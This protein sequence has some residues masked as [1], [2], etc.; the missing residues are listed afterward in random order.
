VASPR[1]ASST[2]RRKAP[3]PKRARRTTA[4]AVTPREAL[5]QQLGDLLAITARSFIEAAVTVEGD[6]ELLATARVLEALSNANDTRRGLGVMVAVDASPE[7]QEREAEVQRQAA[8]EC[9]ALLEKAAYSYTDSLARTLHFRSANG[10]RLPMLPPSSNLGR[11]RAQRLRR[12]IEQARFL[13]R[14]DRTT[15]KGTKLPSLA[16]SLPPE[17]IA[18]MMIMWLREWLADVLPPTVTRERLEAVRAALTA[19]A[20]ELQHEAKAQTFSAKVDNKLAE[21]FVLETLVA[22]GVDR[23]VAHRFLATV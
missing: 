9:I 3:A 21:R 12:M 22:A 10:T 18:G 23:K 5:D 4:P 14:S 19:A 8:R 13:C 7:E 20:A 17:T 15:V 2:T 11:S 1:K 6:D 16:S